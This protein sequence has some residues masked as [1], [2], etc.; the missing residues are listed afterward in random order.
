MANLK[1]LAATAI[2]LLA[3]T[4]VLAVQ[5]GHHHHRYAYSRAYRAYGFYRG[6][7]FAPGNV[8]EDFA[9]RNTFN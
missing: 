8:S 7:D 1:L 4:P 3:A 5:R 9:R 2:S 6:G